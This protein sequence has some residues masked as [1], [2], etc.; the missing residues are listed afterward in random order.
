M[1]TIKTAQNSSPTVCDCGRKLYKPSYWRTD[2]HIGGMLHSVLKNGEWYV[3][4]VCWRVYIWC[5]PGVWKKSHILEIGR[6][7]EVVA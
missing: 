1:K 6:T 7:L 2:F 4:C 3:N 5:F